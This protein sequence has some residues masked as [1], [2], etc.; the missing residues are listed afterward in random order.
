MFRGYYF[1]T[2]GILSKSGNISDV[3]NA[4]LAGVT[5]IQY[6]NKTATT[7]EMY[8]EALMLRKICKKVL[9]L[10]N[11]RVDIAV[12]VNADG[13]HIGQ[14]DLPYPVVRKIIGKNKI[15]GLSVHNVEEAIEAQNYGADY[16]SV[17][18][19]F[20]TETKFDI[21]KPVGVNMIKNIKKV[22]SVPVVAIGGINLS[23]VESVL[24]AGADMVCSISAVV[25]KN[26]VKSEIE[27]YQNLFQKYF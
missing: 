14:D 6:R 11:D 9:F 8:K 2:D 16:I 5:V 21:K 17:G 26:D 22:V 24:K 25:K 13:V 23:N 15:I 18:P 1:I 20:Y 7:K 27:K 4:I 12:A 10:I 19:I 3:K